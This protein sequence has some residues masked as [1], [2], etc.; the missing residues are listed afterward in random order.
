MTEDDLRINSADGYYQ[1]DYPKRPIFEQARG[2][3][4]NLLNHLPAADGYQARP[5]ILNHL[6]AIK[7]HILS[8]GIPSMH[9]FKNLSER[10]NVPQPHVAQ[11]M[12]SQNG[13]FDLSL[14]EYIRNVGFRLDFLK[15]FE[16]TAPYYYQMGCR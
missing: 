5:N 12:S 13:K 8:R 7:E 10:R 9:D 4:P 6:P 11:S 15:I 1:S 16:L 3:N 2:P 14:E